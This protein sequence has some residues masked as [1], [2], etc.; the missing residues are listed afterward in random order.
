MSRISTL[1][2][3]PLM[4]E[5]SQGAA[6][7]AIMPLANFIAPGVEVAT[8]T[9]QYKAWNEKAR[10]RI[11]K[12]ERA[13]GGPATQLRMEASDATYNCK[14]H[15]LDYPLDNLE[16]LE[17][18]DWANLLQEGADVC[19]QVAALAHEKE[20]VDAAL[21]AAGAGADHNFTSAS[22]NPVDILDD[23]AL[24]V[25]KAAKYGSAMGIK[26]VFG[27]T[28]WKRTKNNDKVMDRYRGERTSGIAPSLDD[29]GQMLLAK[30]EARVSF[31]VF[32]DAPEG[33]A[34]D[35]KFVLDNSI[36]VFAN[37]GSPTRHDPSFMKTFRLRGNWM[38]PGVYQKEDGRGEVAKFDW[39]E[40][41]QV[42]NSAA[43]V[44][45]N[46]NDS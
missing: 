1:S 9:G 2:S 10:F 19:A 17:A 5:Y 6:Q 45:I 26:A 8:Q 34:E 24:T 18:S 36:L 44:R 32:D 11:P 31:M 15:A 21:T 22:T 3:S 38:V 13:L 20:V 42:T 41:V 12:T 46:A 28:A 39:S 16:Q 35:I 25:L 27:A 30:P 29:F 7:G 40:D 23:A 4:R 43:V 14:P 37:L 33:L